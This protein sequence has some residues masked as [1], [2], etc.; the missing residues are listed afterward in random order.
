VVN[1]TIA[2]AQPQSPFL[3]E[4]AASELEQFTRVRS[5]SGRVAILPLLPT[6]PIGED[7]L[8]AL[9]ALSPQPV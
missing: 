5:L 3:R 4:R 6:E 1:S 8:A 9:T 7:R 2:A